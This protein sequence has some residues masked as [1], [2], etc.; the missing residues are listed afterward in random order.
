MPVK[1]NDQYRAFCDQYRSDSELPGV[2][3]RW[4]TSRQ[5]EDIRP[6]R[7]IAIVFRD[8]RRCDLN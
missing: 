5:I 1:V 7:A 3:A 8:S 6:R 2:I 4:F